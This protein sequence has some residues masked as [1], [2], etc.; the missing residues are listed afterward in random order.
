MIP[1]FRLVGFIPIFRDA[2]ISRPLRTSTQWIVQYN[3]AQYSTVQYNEVLLSTVH[4]TGDV[5]PAKSSVMMCFPG[6]CGLLHSGRRH[7]PLAV[8]R[9]FRSAPEASCRALQGPCECPEL[10]LLRNVVYDYIAC[11]YACLVDSVKLEHAYLSHKRSYQAQTCLKGTSP[12][13]CACQMFVLGRHGIVPISS[14]H[15]PVLP[16]APGD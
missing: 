2:A 14:L 4:T 9:G 12:V 11:M 16:W 6:H 3:T 13:F 1:F 8:P 7:A 5:H 10:R 15:C